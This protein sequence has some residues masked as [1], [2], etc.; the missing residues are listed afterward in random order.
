[1]SDR[2]YMFEDELTENA[3]SKGFL[4]F[5]FILLNVKNPNLVTVKLIYL[6]INIYI[7][8]PCKRDVA[9]CTGKYRLYFAY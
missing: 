1:M 9:M 2:I 3:K 8:C 7:S 4:I 5:I 6:Y